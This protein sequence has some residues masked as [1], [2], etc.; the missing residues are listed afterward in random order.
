[1]E[2]VKGFDESTA[3]DSFVNMLVSLNYSIKVINKTKTFFILHVQ[4][5]GIFTFTHSI[6]DTKFKITLL[7]N[8]EIRNCTFKL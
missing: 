1:M 8:C 3:H 7:F 4:K 5:K 2:N 6:W